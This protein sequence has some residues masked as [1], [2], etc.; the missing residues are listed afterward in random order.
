MFIFLTVSLNIRIKTKSEI[1][2][3]QWS[4]AE[5]RRFTLCAKSHLYSYF[6]HLWKGRSFSRFSTVFSSHSFLTK[7]YRK[8]FR[9]F[10]SS[11]PTWL[12]C[13][14]FFTVFVY[15]YSLNLIWYK[16]LWFYCFC[17]NET[18]FNFYQTPKLFSYG[19]PC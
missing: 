14:L 13:D 19:V 2:I 17:H 11:F 10:E 15:I 1:R 3:S 4:S 7:Q 12:Y 5:Y 16:I 18:I 8:F 6:L 9:S